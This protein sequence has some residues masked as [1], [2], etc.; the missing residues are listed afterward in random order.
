MLEDEQLVEEELVP[1]FEEYVQVRQYYDNI[2][3]PPLICH[4][5][6]HRYTNCFLGY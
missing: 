5:H 6:R 1:I 2:S 3:H 4:H